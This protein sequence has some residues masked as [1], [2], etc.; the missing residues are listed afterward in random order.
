[1]HS[2]KIEAQLVDRIIGLESETR[3]ALQASVRERAGGDADV[4]TDFQLWDV[5]NRVTAAAKE[6]DFTRRAKLQR[7]G[8]NLLTERMS[9]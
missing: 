2:L 3:Q 1:M 9:R 8:G 4:A 5:H 6:F 7:L